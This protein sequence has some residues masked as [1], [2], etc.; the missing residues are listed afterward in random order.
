MIELHEMGHFLNSV[1]YQIPME[2]VSLIYDDVDETITIAGEVEDGDLKGLSLEGILSA[3]IGGKA[4]E[5]LV[6]GHNNFISSSFD[7]LYNVYML[8]SDIMKEP[9]SLTR[10]IKAFTHRKNN[11][12]LSI[13]KFPKSLVE[14]LADKLTAEKEWDKKT[15]EQIIEDYNLLEIAETALDDFNSGSG[16]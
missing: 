15:I 12:T 7:S 14:E 11:A 6:K 4:I 8:C 1:C 10:H 13:V 9:S 2:Q 3:G 5:E 16:I